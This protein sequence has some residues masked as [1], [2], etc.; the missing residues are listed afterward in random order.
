MDKVIENVLSAIDPSGFKQEGAYNLRVNGKGVCHSD[1]E[2]VKIVAKTD[3]PGIDIYVSGNAR[4]EI[5]KIPVVLSADNMTDKVYNDFHIEDGASVYIMAGCG[6][7]NCG[8]GTSQ[9][10]G[11]HTF[12]IGKNCHVTYTENHYGEGTGDGKRIL[13]PVTV[14]HVGE[15]STC[16]MDLA[17]IKGVDSTKKETDFYLA[18]NSRLQVTEKLLTHADQYAESN[19][20]VVLEGAKSSAKVISRSVAKEDSSQVFHPVAVGEAKCQAH[21]QCDSIIMDQ[22]KVRSIPEIDARNLDAAI[23]HEAAIGRINNEQLMKLMTFGLD[24]AEAEA[25][26]IDNFLH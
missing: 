22:A 13:N 5:V 7:H 21:I 1:S 6:I 25:V 24:E 12:Y 14:A 3:K 9:H 23:I 18:E 16:V 17:Q 10:D 2:N 4:H 8:N 19:M 20:K 26:I 15:G 11:V